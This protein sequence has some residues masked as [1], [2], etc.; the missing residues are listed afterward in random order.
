MEKLF[1]IKE[2][3]EY[4]AITR[5]TLYNWKDAGKINFSDING[6][7]RIKESELKRIIGGL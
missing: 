3:C 2:V 6:R 7:V 1:T 4:L 5:K